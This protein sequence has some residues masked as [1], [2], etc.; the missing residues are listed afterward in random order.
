MQAFSNQANEASSIALVST[1]EISPISNPM[2]WAK[3]MGEASKSKALMIVSVGVLEKDGATNGKEVK[4]GSNASSRSV[5][6]VSSTTLDS[7]EKEDS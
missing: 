4:G 3:G 1:L 7:R 5:K 6:S 2:H